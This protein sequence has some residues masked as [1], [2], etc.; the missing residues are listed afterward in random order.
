MNKQRLLELAGIVEAKYTRGGGDVFVTWSFEDDELYLHGPFHSE[1][2]AQKYIEWEM[3]EFDIEPDMEEHVPRI[4][5]VYPPG[6]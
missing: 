5:Q 6:E 4:A 1:E 2:E 3:R